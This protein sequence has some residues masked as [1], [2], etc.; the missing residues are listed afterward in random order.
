M[1]HVMAFFRR[2]GY[3]VFAWIAPQLYHKPVRSCLI[4]S[5]KKC[6]IYAA[7]GVLQMPIKHYL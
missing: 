7:F 3:D 5:K 4:F 2:L 6:R 1:M